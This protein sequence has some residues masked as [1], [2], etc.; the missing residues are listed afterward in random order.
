MR[1]N[2]YTILFALLVVAAGA[3][4]QGVV[5]PPV[6]SFHP[7]TS[8]PS[9]KVPEF[10]VTGKT[11]VELPKAAKPVIEIDSDYFRNR[12]LRGVVVDVPLNRNISN[13]NLTSA[14]QSTSLF[15]R[16]SVG[17]YTTTRYLISGAG[18]V[19]GFGINGGLSGDYTSGFIPGTKRR[20]FSIHAGITKDINSQDMMKSSNS[21]NLGYARSSYSLYGGPQPILERS[22]AQT[23]FDLNSDMYLGELPLA[24]SLNFNRFSVDD[25]WHNTTSSLN[26][27][28]STQIQLLSG[29]LGFSGSFLF[30][31]HDLSGTPG[32]ALQPLPVGFYATSGLSRSIYNLRLGGSYGNSSLLGVFSY[33][34]GADYY[35][36]RDDSSNTV[37]KIFPA[38]RASYRISPVVSLFASFSGSVRKAD[39]SSF[40]SKDM[41]V[42][43]AIPLVNTQVNADFMLGMRLEVTDNLELMPNVRV[44]SAKYFPVFISYP[45][46]INELLYVGKA[47]ITSL[48]VTAKYRLSDLSARMVLRYEKASA[49]SLSSIPNIPALDANF[50]LTYRITEKLSAEAGLLFLS[51]RYADLALSEKVDPAGLLNARLAYDF[52]FAKIP[53]E[54]FA[55]GDNILDE[56]YFIWHGYREFPM[57]LYVGLSSKIL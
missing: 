45:T 39:L 2:A 55:G 41:Y 35:Q 24:F 34:I 30:G 40:V 31:T 44:R 9:V 13:Q 49:D 8:M 47:E 6:R 54:V 5:T 18:G 28:A 27:Q 25:F 46:K 23:K 20:D 33:S 3:R 42:D 36:Y 11:Q 22:T 37:A 12:D 51:G 21:M 7:D 1:V 19:D 4:A 53:F 16:A 10:V 50:G 52:N 48:S 14:N 29:W 17:H 38:I 43:G 56:K 57:T 15:A 26:L 32:V